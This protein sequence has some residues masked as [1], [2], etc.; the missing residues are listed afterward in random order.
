[1]LDLGGF[2][3]EELATAL[4][5]Q[6]DCEHRWLMDSVFL[7]WARSTSEATTIDIFEVLE[8]RG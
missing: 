5:D 2:D 6:T 7:G 4:A 1:M 8:P 3:L